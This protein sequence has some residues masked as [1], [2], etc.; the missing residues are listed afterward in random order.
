MS[1]NVGRREL[2]GA[3]G[4]AAVWPLAA[5]AQQPAM[6][7]VGFLH[8]G[9]ASGFAGAQATAFRE[10]LRE[11]GYKRGTKCPDRISLGRGPL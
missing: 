6:P 11:T 5:S 8:G 2:I 1:V 10:G 3:L 4:G 7:A 9:R